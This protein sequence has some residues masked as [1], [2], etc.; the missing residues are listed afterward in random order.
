LAARDRQL[1]LFHPTPMAR[2]LLMITGLDDVL[3][4]EPDTP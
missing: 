1:I 3:H 2:R 4:I